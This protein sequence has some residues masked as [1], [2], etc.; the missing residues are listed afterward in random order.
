MSGAV[1]IGGLLEESTPEAPSGENLEYDPGF[2]ELVRLAQGKPEQQMGDAVVPGEEPD[3]RA[4]RSKS[5]ELLARSKDIRLAVYLT[6]ALLRTDGLAGLSDGLALTHGLLE[7]HWDTLH[8]QLDPEDDNDPTM[9]V[10]TLVALCDEDA[11]LR[12]VRETPLVASRAIGRFSLKDVLVAT[13]Q[14]PAPASKDTIPDTATIDAAVMDTDLEALQATGAALARAHELTGAVEMVLTEKVGVG[15]AADFS[16]LSNLLKHA[17]KV[18]NEWLLHRGV[19][20]EEDAGDAAG[21][22]DGAAR[23]VTGAINSREDVLRVLDRMCAYF[24]QHEP[25]SPVPL[26]LK[27]A[28]RLVS[29]DFLE[30]LRDLAPDGV[31]QAEAIRGPDEGS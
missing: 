29:K 16:E 13:G 18:V 28:K 25:S 12:A 26:L 9:R 10:N 23:S 3:W 14:L 15:Q 22:A 6:R 8:P 24:A 4:V 30:I 7:R 17:G 20:V 5:L 2:V 31:A 21:G 19:G 11:V 27:R 1:D